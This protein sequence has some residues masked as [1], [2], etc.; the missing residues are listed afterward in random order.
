MEKRLAYMLL[1]VKQKERNQQ[2]DQDV[3]KL[4]MSRYT[5]EREDGVLSTGFLGLRIGRSGKLL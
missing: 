2:E 1:M 3:G 5:L 4:I